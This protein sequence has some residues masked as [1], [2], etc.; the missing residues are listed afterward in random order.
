MTEW[1]MKS[2]RTRTGAIRTSRR[3]SDKRLAWKGG[4]AAETIVGEKDKRKKKRA[5]GGNSK[6]KMKAAKNASVTVPGQKKAVKAEIVAVL[7]NQANRLYTR[8]NIITKGATITVKVD[9][10]EEKARVTSRP[11]QNGV[12]QAVLVGK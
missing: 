5:A 6:V 4:H 8:K 9:G 1:H 3:R 11:G 12:V 10:K 7:E 2:K